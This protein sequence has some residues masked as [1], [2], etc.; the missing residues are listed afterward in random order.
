MNA[1]NV[2]EC[3]SNCSA[4]EG[5]TKG[6][7]GLCSRKSLLF[8]FTDDQ[9]RK[10]EEEIVGQQLKA[11]VSF[12]MHSIGGFEVCSHVTKFSPSPIFSPLLFSIVSMVTD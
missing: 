8:D 11:E 9:R 4:W 5:V 6:V 7:I 2:S 10:V 1:I 3:N 12:K